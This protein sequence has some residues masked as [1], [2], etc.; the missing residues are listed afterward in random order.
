MT[1]A[2]HALI[3]GPRSN[4]VGLRARNSERRKDGRTG[5]QAAEGLL[6]HR[7][8][9]VSARA[10]TGG[11]DVSNRRP[12]SADENGIDN[13][14]F[15]HVSKT[16]EAFFFRGLATSNLSAVFLPLDSGHQQS[17]CLI[18]YP[19]T[20][21]LKEPSARKHEKHESKTNEK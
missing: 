2:W 11:I 14:I 1:I 17:C 4:R 21:G 8:Q 20:R 10:T 5:A 6:L 7:Q 18:D 19:P 16:E 12:R 3:S 13:N 9:Q 15:S